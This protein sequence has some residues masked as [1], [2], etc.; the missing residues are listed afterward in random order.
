MTDMRHTLAPSRSKYLA[1]VS[2]ASR[3]D[4]GKARLYDVRGLC[5]FVLM[6]VLPKAGGHNAREQASYLNAAIFEFISKRP[7][8]RT[9][10][11]PD[12]QRRSPS[13]GNARLIA[14][15][16]GRDEWRDHIAVVIAEN[17]DL[18]A[19]DLLVPAEANVVTTLLGRRRRAIAVGDA[20]VEKAMLFEHQYRALEDRV[21][22]ATANPPAKRR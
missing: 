3:T 21:E 2:V 6:A 9:N 15:A 7:R 13:R 5:N 20:D 18:V 19:L 1:S 14:I 4:G 10:P 17:D 22:T 16:L 12:H 11:S 8:K